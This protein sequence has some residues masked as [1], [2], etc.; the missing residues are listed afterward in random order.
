MPL[1]SKKSPR[2]LA[3]N[4]V[5]QKRNYLL[6]IAT[7]L[8]VSLFCLS[9]PLYV[10]RPFRHQGP[11]EL[12]VALQILRFRPG[13]EMICAVT[14]LLAGFLYWRA[15]PKILPRVA[16]MFAVALVC[17]FAGLSR[18]NTFEIMFHPMG[19]PN[20]AVAGDTKLDSAEMVMAVHIGGE[21]R[22]YPIRIVSYH[23]IVNDVVGGVPIVATY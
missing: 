19:R 23:H 1:S 2:L 20:L 9:Y 16:V 11:R 12:A 13:V 4:S 6:S 10:I 8:A 15:Q 21:A 7:V 18:V 14:A 3:T 5:D 17:L 22:A